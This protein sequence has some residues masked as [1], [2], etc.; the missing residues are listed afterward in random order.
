[1][2]H[3]FDAMRRRKQRYQ[4]PPPPEPVVIDWSDVLL[5]LSE[6]FEIVNGQINDRLNA[7]SDFE[8]GELAALRREQ[9]FLEI[10]IDRVG[11]LSL[12][13]ERQED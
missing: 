8:R 10:V 4:P 9:T 11:D 5:D 7:V 3:P 2:T 1:M 13:G 12:P 6:R